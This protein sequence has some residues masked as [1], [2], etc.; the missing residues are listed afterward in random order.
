MFG[1]KEMIV[2]A[3]YLLGHWTLR[4]KPRRRETAGIQELGSRKMF[5][6]RSNFTYLQSIAFYIPR[7]FYYTLNSI[8]NEV[9]W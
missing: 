5:F 2:N 8:T 7:V 6:W 1:G 9:W 3:I 4:Q